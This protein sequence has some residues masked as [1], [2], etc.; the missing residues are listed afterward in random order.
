M[1]DLRLVADGPDGLLHACVAV[2]TVTDTPQVSPH[3]LSA[4]L[5]PFA[6]E[7]DATAALVAAGGQSVRKGERR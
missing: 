7:E 5:K 1:A 6:S 2:G 4:F 3:R